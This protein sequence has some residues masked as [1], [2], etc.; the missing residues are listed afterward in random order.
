MKINLKCLIVIL[1][2]LSANGCNKQTNIDVILTNVGKSN[3]DSATLFVTGNSYYLG[4]LVI[5]ESVS[6]KI[7]PSSESHLELEFT[8]LEKRRKRLTVGSYFKPGYSG[9]I[10][11]SLTADSV[12]SVNDSINISNY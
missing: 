3:L 2:L 10:T 5:N 9:V 11:I 1:T 7:Y 6:Q 4:H 12:V 8:S